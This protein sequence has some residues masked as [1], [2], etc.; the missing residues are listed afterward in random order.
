[1]TEIRNIELRNLEV[2]PSGRRIVGIAA[3]YGTLSGDLGGFKEKIA[4]TAFLKS[5]GENDIR[6]L[7][8]HDSAKILGRISAGT[9]KLSSNDRGLEFDLTLPNTSYAN[10]LVELMARGDVTSCSFGF[11][12][13]SDKWSMDPETKI[14]IRTLHDVDLREI[15]IV[16]DP[17]YPSGTSAALRSLTAWQ[18]TLDTRR[19]RCLLSFLKRRNPP[20][21]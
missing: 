2:N 13:R 7:Y 9:L 21:S 16:G 3:A 14:R 15:S 8:N 11:F 5:I 19:K 6:A 18:S 10:D 1:V 4:P 17:A 12:T 20:R